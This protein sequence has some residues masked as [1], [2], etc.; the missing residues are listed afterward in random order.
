MASIDPLSTGESTDASFV[1]LSSEDDAKKMTK[2][3][4]AK[5]RTDVR[6]A[7]VEEDESTGILAAVQAPSG[8]KILHLLNYP[9]WTVEKKKNKAFAIWTPVKTAYNQWKE[10]GGSKNAISS[11]KRLKEVLEERKAKREATAHLGPWRIPLVSHWVEVE[12]EEKDRGDPNV[13]W[14][15]ALVMKHCNGGCFRVKVLQGDG[16]FTPTIEYFFSR[17]EEGVFWRRLLEGTPSSANMSVRAEAEKLRLKPVESDESESEDIDTTEDEGESDSDDESPSE[18]ESSD[19][20][21]SERRS[22]GEVVEIVPAKKKEMAPKKNAVQKTTT[23]GATEPAHK[24]KAGNSS[25]AHI[26]ATRKGEWKAFDDR[27]LKDLVNANPDNWDWVARELGG[28]RNARSVKMRYQHLHGPKKALPQPRDVSN[29]AH[30]PGSAEKGGAH[31]TA[32]KG[33]GK[34]AAPPAQRKRSAPSAGSDPRAGSG[35][36]PKCSG[37]QHAV[38]GSASRAA[39]VGKQPG[40]QTDG[41]RQVI[42]ML[43]AYKLEQYAETM[44]SEGYDDIEFITT[45]DEVRLEKIASRVGMLHGHAQK[46]IEYVI[47]KKKWC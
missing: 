41:M 28:G 22:V 16:G 45:G 9:G 47:S 21:E 30:S 39:A 37:G 40:A 31:E 33:P 44:A 19:D 27:L 26:A 2:R 43:Q 13:L 25:N 17:Y 3:V 23:T 18:S 29:R 46:F 34:P 8:R 15:P 36:A 12:L 7:T 5:V 35:K 4:M 32:Q 14:R 1:E 6:E 20:S 42:Q 38:P 24:R 11:M 10:G